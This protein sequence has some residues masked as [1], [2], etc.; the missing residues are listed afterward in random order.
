MKK[1]I[2]VIALVA[3]VFVGDRVGGMM[4]KFLT[5]HS[6]FRYSRLYKGKGE[7]DI[8]L[9]GNSRGLV[10]YQPYIEEIT[11][12]KTFNIS[13]NGMHISLARVLMEDYLER[14][15]A[16]KLILFEVSM[17]DYS[18]EKLIPS[19][20]LHS[21][22]SKGI[23]SLIFHYDPTTA[24][25][26][27]V[28]HLYRYNSEVFQRSLY[29]L[30]KSDKFWL[31]D[32]KINDNVIA[33][34]GEMEQVEFSLKEERQEELKRIVDLSKKYGTDIRLVLNPYFP[35]YADKIV[36]LEAWKSQ[37]EALTGEKVYDY[38]RA[39]ADFTSFADYTHLNK[40]GSKMYIEQLNKDHIFEVDTE[41][42]V[43]RLKP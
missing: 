3:L 8:L 30:N 21:E 20:A 26:S 7:S 41:A 24:W 23:D 15:K 32:R 1:V 39:I 36:N 19:F 28:S 12:A 5:D 9:V 43:L 34:L 37:I 25:A 33:E 31:L 42:V 10:F 14:H 40:Y 16:P 6:Q 13:Y 38:T 29:Y 18:D 35:P 27:K 4:L 17:A 22:E 2:W 11:D